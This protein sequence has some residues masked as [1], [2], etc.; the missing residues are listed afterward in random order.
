MFHS[1]DVHLF[2]RILYYYKRSST[3]VKIAMSEADRGTTVPELWAAVLKGGWGVDFEH[4]QPVR[5]KVSLDA[6]EMPSL[7]G[8]RRMAPLRYAGARS[9][10]FRVADSEQPADGAPRST[11][12]RAV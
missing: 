9:E 7:R 2:F 3:A 10:L 12:H 8:S 1:H 5:L 6:V 11:H 4:R